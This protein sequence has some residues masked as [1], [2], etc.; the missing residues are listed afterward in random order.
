MIDLY[1]RC[2][3]PYVV[4][5][6]Y[7][8]GLDPPYE[9]VGLFVD[10]AR[11]RGVRMAVSADLAP[12]VIAPWRTPTTSVLY[13]A[14]VVDPP[15]SSF[16]QAPARGEATVVLRQISDETLLSAWPTS[17]TGIPLAHPVQQVWDLY[18]LGGEDRI[19]AAQRLIDVVVG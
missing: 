16:V 5:E 18:D 14:D 11:R 15:S 10:A 6:S 4:A 19:E 12:D 2:H 3:R 17:L 1:V 8:Y 13:V 9:Q 7:F